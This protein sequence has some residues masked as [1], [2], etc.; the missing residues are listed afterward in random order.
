MFTRLTVC[1]RCG[2]ST[3]AAEARYYSGGCPR[4]TRLRSCPGCGAYVPTGRLH[5]IR[6]LITAWHSPLDWPPPGTWLGMLA[7]A[8]GFAV[9]FGTLRLLATILFGW[10]SR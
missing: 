10:P 7:V 5:L 2:S 8:A 9:V 6:H 4:C 3:P 1:E